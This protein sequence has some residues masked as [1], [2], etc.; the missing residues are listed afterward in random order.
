MAFCEI[1]RDDME[2]LLSKTLDLASGSR[3]HFYISD[4]DPFSEWSGLIATKLRWATRFLKHKPLV[5]ADDLFIPQDDMISWVLRE[6]LPP[7]MSPGITSILQEYT[8]WVTHY[9][10]HPFSSVC[11]ILHNYSSTVTSHKFQHPSCS[12]HG[13][14]EDTMHYLRSCAEDARRQN[15]SMEDV[16]GGIKWHG[17][18]DLS[19]TIAQLIDYVEQ[20]IKVAESMRR[21]PVITTMSWDDYHEKRELFLRHHQSMAEK[22]RGRRPDRKDSQGEGLTQ[23][24]TLTVTPRRFAGLTSHAQRLRRLQRLDIYF[25]RAVFTEELDHQ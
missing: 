4:R 3:M 5:P 6:S 16:L 7:K 19:R 23:Y 10:G 22:V 12:R 13:S 8:F 1:R 14:L 15:R 2:E 9:G 21:M 24:S 18:L 25:R 20:L 17:V 11:E